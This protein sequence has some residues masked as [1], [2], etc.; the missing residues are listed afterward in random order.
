M[1]NRGPW[2]VIAVV[3]V[4]LVVIVGGGTVLGVGPLGATPPPNEVTDPKEMIARSLQAT[5]DATSV[6]LEGTISGT[7]P[8]ALVGSARKRTR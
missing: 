1:Q 2:P 7:I 3:L 8:G 6:H 5:I 4:V